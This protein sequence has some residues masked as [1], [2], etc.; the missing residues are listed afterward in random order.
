MAFR[1]TTVAYNQPGAPPDTPAKVNTELQRVARALGV[2]ATF[3]LDTHTRDVTVDTNDR[4]L[5]L[6]PGS[7]ALG[8]TITVKAGG[9]VMVL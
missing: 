5:L 7:T 8:V 1:T 6:G 4:W 3:H 2:P 9:V